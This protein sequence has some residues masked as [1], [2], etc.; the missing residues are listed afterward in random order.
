MPI[1][2]S[3]VNNMKL[4][5]SKIDS[6][7]GLEKLKELIGHQGGNIE[8]IDHPEKLM[9]ARI[10]IP[11]E[12][13]ESGYVYEIEAKNIGQAVVN[14]GGGRLRKEDQV[15]TSVGIEVL[16]KVGDKV[17]KGEILMYIHANNEDARNQVE[18]LRN[19]YKLA[20]RPVGKLKEIL[21]VIE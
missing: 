21:D 3:I 8:V 14:L 1:C 19:S 17:E 13:L 12:A 16:K 10:K 20:N 4:I 18:F 2:D 15:D 7:E 9:K 11:V 5:Q 6:G